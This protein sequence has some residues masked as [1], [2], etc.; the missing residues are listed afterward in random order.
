MFLRFFRSFQPI[1]YVFIIIISIFL[2]MPAFINAPEIV[3]E[4]TPMPLFSFLSN[5][6]GGSKIAYVIFAYLLVLIQ[7][8]L[9]TR[10]NMKYL[11]IKVRSYLPTLLFLLIT[12]GI[13]RLQTL[14]PGLIASLLILIVLNITLDTFNE[15]KLNYR[16][17]EASIV[18]GVGSL[19]Y[20]PLLYLMLLVWI[21][22]II[23][24]PYNWREWA[25]TILGVIVPG[26]FAFS[27]YYIFKDSPLK[28]FELFK[29]NLIINP[30]IPDLNISEIHF[31][32]FLV[33]ML[34][35][36]SLHLIRIFRLKKA[37][38]RRFFIVFF[39]V[40]ICSMGLFFL[41]P[42]NIHLIYIVSLPFTLV[43]ANYF[44]L[45]ERFR[46]GN[47]LLFLFILMTVYAQLISYQ[48]INYN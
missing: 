8:F 34:I 30:G 13:T 37:H 1:V 5:I 40:F 39:W 27:Y 48:V 38:S 18:I 21:A 32:I 4:E 15:K 24:R 25:F 7:A 46:W 3:I 29:T 23:L 14:S 47:F 28:I 43:L 2:W 31:G 9:L 42:N 6:L 11:F 17:F 20:A 22:L 26:I 35:I 19:F 16:Y 12:S 33:I 36:V 45:V 41:F 44:S 10:L